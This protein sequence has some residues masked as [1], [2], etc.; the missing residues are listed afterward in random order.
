MTAETFRYTFA[1]TLKSTDDIAQL[2]RIDARRKPGGAH[3]VTEHHGKLTAFSI[4]VSDVAG[5]IEVPD[6]TQESLPVSE[7]QA[8][9]FEIVV[10]DI[11]EDIEV[12][13]MF[14]KRAGVLPEPECCQPLIDAAIHAQ[15]CS[16][17][18]TLAYYN[19]SVQFRR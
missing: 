3:H 9:F 19:P 15:E 10:I 18:T 17:F 12:D 8:Q 5:E 13:I 2:L 16:E 11:D 1:A 4:T 7:R 14:D 6:S